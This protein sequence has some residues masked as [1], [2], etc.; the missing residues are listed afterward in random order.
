MSE[1]FI[2]TE[3]F[4]MSMMREAEFMKVYDFRLQSFASGE[5]TL[6]MPFNGVFQRPGGIVS[7]PLIMAL[8]DVTAWAAC[9]TL[10]GESGRMA[11]TTEMHTAFLSAA[12]NEDVYCN[13]KVMK[14]GRRLIYSTAECL[15]K[16]GKL[17]AHHT[18]TYI[19]PQSLDTA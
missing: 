16:S 19:N 15:S 5:C 18:I 7:G 17:F 8:A 13:A 11:V 9:I 2:P 4:L 10:L 14:F 12:K 1:K 6:V 3:A